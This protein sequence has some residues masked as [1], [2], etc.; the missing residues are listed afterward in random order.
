SDLV[1]S[2]ETIDRLKSLVIDKL[3]EGPQN[4]S[5]LKTCMNTS[6]K[7]AIP[8]LEYFDRMGITKRQDD[9]RI[10]GPNAEH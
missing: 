10:L 4:A 7:Y 5:S 2:T 9:A 8:L 1:F 3:S 6:R